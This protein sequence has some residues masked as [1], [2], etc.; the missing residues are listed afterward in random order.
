[1][2]PLSSSEVADSPVLQSSAIVD[3]TG[4]PGRRAGSPGSR[5]QPAARTNGRIRH[6]AR[7]QTAIDV[8]RRRRRRSSGRGHVAPAPRRPRRRRS[9]P[10]TRG[11]ARYV[12]RRRSIGVCAMR[13]PSRRR[14]EAHSGG[15]VVRR[16][17]CDSRYD[18]SITAAAAASTAARRALRGDAGLRAVPRSAITVVNRSSCVST[19]IL[20][21]PRSQRRDLRQHAPGGGTVVARERQRQADHDA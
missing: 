21:P 2:T 1:M 12:G 19:S 3:A 10:A 11:V 5:N 18:W 4:S 16:S 13:R 14:R 6:A 15:S 7:S 9:P 17:R 20:R 8:R